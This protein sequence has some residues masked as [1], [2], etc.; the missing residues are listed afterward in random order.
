MASVSSFFEALPPPTMQPH[1]L[2]ARLFRYASSAPYS[3]P[4]WQ[5]AHEG[6]VV[7]KGRGTAQNP[8]SA[9]VCL[10]AC[11]ARPERQADVTFRRVHQERGHGG[12]T[13]H[14]VPESGLDL[15]GLQGDRH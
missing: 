13:V 10:C 8:S 14:T 3:I 7:S 12:R 9:P 6:A 4:D 11:V 2:C 1:P 5:T 15:H